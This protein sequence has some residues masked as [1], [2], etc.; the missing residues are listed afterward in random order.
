[1]L[2]KTLKWIRPK[3]K[4]LRAGKV[5]LGRCCWCPLLAVSS[6]CS[7]CEFPASETCW[8]EDRAHYT[9]VDFRTFCMSQRLHCIDIF[10]SQTMSSFDSEPL[11]AWW[12]RGLSKTTLYTVLVHEGHGP[13]EGA[14]QRGRTAQFLTSGKGSPSFISSS[15]D[16][17][18]LILTRDFLPPCPLSYS[19]PG[20][21]TPWSPPPVAFVTCS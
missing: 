1:M 8:P 20:L 11:G 3:N 18:E 16:L 5:K 2:F 14:F 17:M 10:L 4:C 9:C 12:T 6:R 7:I 13:E 19:P 15:Q 21:H